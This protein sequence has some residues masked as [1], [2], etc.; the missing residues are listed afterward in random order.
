[1]QRAHGL[2]STGLID[3]RENDFDAFLHRPKGIGVHGLDALE[4]FQILLGD[5]LHDS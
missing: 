1:V 4:Q 2:D 3:H 5:C